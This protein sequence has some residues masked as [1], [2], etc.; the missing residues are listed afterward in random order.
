MTHSQAIPAQEHNGKRRG[1]PPLG[2]RN[3]MRHGLRS[4]GM[5]KGC[6]RY[7]SQLNDLRRQL[8]DEVLEVHG[9]V[10]LV[11]ALAILTAM[12]WERHAVLAARWL[13]LEGEQMSPSDR[14]NYSR[15]IARASA[16]RDVA[17]KELGLTRR[18]SDIW[19]TL[20]L[21]NDDECTRVPERITVQVAKD[22]PDAS[23]GALEA[24]SHG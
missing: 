19:Q 4:A 10:S 22:S 14:L 1:G 7:E 24:D 21:P 6:R 9:R 11:H 18:N 12:R 20:H 17:I 5:P 3:A 23:A 16:A 8:E 2:S 13:R 15:E